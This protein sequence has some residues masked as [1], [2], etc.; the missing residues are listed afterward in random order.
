MTRNAPNAVQQNSSFSKLAGFPSEQSL[1]TVVPQDINGTAR[2]ITPSQSSSLA[3]AGSLT[4]SS[5]YF[6]LPFLLPMHFLS[7]LCDCPDGDS[8][9]R[10][11]AQGG[12]LL[13]PRL[14]MSV[15]WMRATHLPTAAR[16][17]SSEIGMSPAQTEKRQTK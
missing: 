4:G 10:L 5:L 13:T 1:D 12:D 8:H 3:M 7:P 15:R 6:F 2:T 16:H 17:C 14:M 9:S 11:E